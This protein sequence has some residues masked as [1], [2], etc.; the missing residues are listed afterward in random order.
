MKNMVY[1]III[2]FVLPCLTSAG[3]IYTYKNKQGVTVIS[4]EP[5]PD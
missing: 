4:N 2:L 3:E 5:P 1:I